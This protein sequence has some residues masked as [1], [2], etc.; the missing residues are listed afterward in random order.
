MI[1][2]D[3]ND[4]HLRK[5]K[6][7][8]YGKPQVVKVIFPPG[9]GNIALDEVQSILGT[10]WLEQKYV[11]QCTLLKNE[12]R[13]EPIHLFAA[14]ELLIRN[15]CL[16]DI[17]LIIFQIQLNQFYVQVK[18][19]TKRNSLLSKIFFIFFYLIDEQR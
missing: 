12:I 9:L 8:I 18:Y 11:S 2:P 3:K 7:N 15:Q 5:M 19:Q 16:T 1:T 4:N 13:I 6:K 14:T 10:L 17:R